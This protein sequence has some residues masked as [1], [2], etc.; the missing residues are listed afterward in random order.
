[1]TR[2]YPIRVQKLFFYR[3]IKRKGKRGVFEKQSSEGGEEFYLSR[4]C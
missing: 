1:M 2:K 3:K 4:S